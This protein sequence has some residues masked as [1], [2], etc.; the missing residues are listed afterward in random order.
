MASST[1]I[2]EKW[3]RWSRQLWQSWAEQHG[4][5]VTTQHEKAM[6]KVSAYF[7][8]AGR[9]PGVAEVVGLGTAAD[10]VSSMQ[11]LEPESKQRISFR[12]AVQVGLLA[13]LVQKESDNRAFDEV[14]RGFNNPD[15]VIGGGLAAHVEG[16]FS[17][18]PR[19]DVWRTPGFG[20]TPLED[21]INLKGQDPGLDLIVCRVLAV[22]PAG[23]RFKVD[24]SA[25]F[26]AERHVKVA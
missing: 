19:G 10:L 7:Q 15:G 4:P 26:L 2:I 3:A 16:T 1:D 9:E 12:V 20:L 18:N 24:G 13:E 6:H 14:V 8:K 5:Q 22:R 23:G 17:C 11:D 25:V 21:R